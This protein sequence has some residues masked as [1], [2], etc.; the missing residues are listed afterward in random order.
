MIHLTLVL[1]D[2]S[3]PGG[4]MQP[5]AKI[6]LLYIAFCLNTVVVSVVNLDKTTR[7]FSNAKPENDLKK[8]KKKSSTK[9]DWNEEWQTRTFLF[10]FQLNTLA[11]YEGDTEKKLYHCESWMILYLQTI[12]PQ[13]LIEELQHD[14][15]L[16]I[17]VYSLSPRC[18]V[19]HC[20][21]MVL[22]IF[23]RR[24]MHDIFWYPRNV[25]TY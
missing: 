25:E 8:K 18:S 2:V 15:S 5:G 12:Q 11:L 16:C 7:F 14:I 22:C 13:G 19:Q 1:K 17:I 6:Q 9:S 4:H 10:Y 21:L 3:M 23:G 20:H 24:E